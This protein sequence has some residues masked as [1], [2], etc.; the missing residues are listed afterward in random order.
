MKR[1]LFLLL[2]ILLTSSAV[3]S[4]NIKNGVRVSYHIT[5]KQIEFINVHYDYVETPFLNENIRNKIQF[6]EL[7]LYRSIRSTWENFTEFDWNHINSHENMF[8]HSDSVD[9]SENTRIFIP[10]Y[11][12]WLMDGNDLVDSSAADAI[13]HWVNYFAVTASAQLYD[14]HYDGLY[15]DEAGN[16]LS[17][18]AVNGIMP[19]DYTSESWRDGRYRALRFIKSY[20]PDKTV[21]FNGLHADN[22]ADSSLSLTDG[23]MWEDFAYDIHNGSYKGKKKW[24]EA[25]QCMQENNKNTNL[26]LVVKKPGLIDNFQ[27]R[28]FSVASYLLISNANVILSLSDYAHNTSL[29]YYPEYEISLGNPMGDFTMTT[30]SLF[31]REFENGMVLV[32]PDSNSTRTYILEKE[33]NKTVPIGGGFVDSEGK[34]TGSLSYDKISGQ[35]EIPPVSALILKDS[36]QSGTGEAPSLSDIDLLTQNYPNPFYS[37]TTI[38]FSIKKKGF[39]NLNVYDMSGKLIATLVNEEKSAGEFSVIFDGSGLQRGIYFYSLKTN[40]IVLQRKMVLE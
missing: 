36:L 21:I 4:G 28:I 3:F 29:Q 26:V 12:S 24:W 9:Q 35:V 7:L 11:G 23:G 38:R 8:C 30:D 15:I 17:P 22:G 14:Y 6:P 19:W 33:Y 39:V 20:F 34:Y 37:L 5:D 10:E 2:I 1:L 25:I 40:G 13:N 16:K 18:G 31:I 32:N 27:A